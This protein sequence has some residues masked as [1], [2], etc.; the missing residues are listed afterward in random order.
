MDVPLTKA[1]VRHVSD[2]CLRKGLFTTV[3]GSGGP[4]QG[5]IVEDR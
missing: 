3:L 2:I 4:M 1:I 5:R